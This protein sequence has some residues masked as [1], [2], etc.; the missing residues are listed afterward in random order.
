MKDYNWNIDKLEK[1]ALANQDFDDY[2][3]KQSKILTYKNLKVLDIGCSNGFKTN[4]LFGK[5]KNIEKV[6]GIDID[7]KAIM[8]AKEKYE[9]NKYTFELKDI[10]QLD[11]NNKYDIIYLS[12]VLQH[13]KEPK[14]YLKKL[15]NML[16]DRGIIIIKVP[17]DSFK[18]CYPDKE[19]LLNKIFKLYE[20]KIINKQNITKYTDRHIGKKVFSYLKENNYQNVKLYYN[21]TDTLNMTCDEKLKLFNSSIY[22]R[23]AEKKTNVNEKVKNE[24]NEL[25]NKL[26]EKFKQENFYY[27]MTVLYYTAKK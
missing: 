14:Q 21:I 25:L 5:Y 9:D 13:L 8:E 17:D 15:K 10:D 12:Y 7:D 20:D 18:L 16:T 4:L 3:L 1:Q 27:V 6:V 23:N 11:T 24:M 2:V 26:K 19:D 22:F